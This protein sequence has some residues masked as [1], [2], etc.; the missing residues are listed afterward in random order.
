MS[1]LT[2]EV[3]HRYRLYPVKWLNVSWTPVTGLNGFAGVLGQC[4]GL[5]YLEICNNDIGADGV[6]RLSPGSDCTVTITGCPL[7][8]EQSDQRCR[9]RE[10]C[11]SG[12]TSRDT[13]TDTSH[14]TVL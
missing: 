6:E 2:G 14:V 9:D 1:V 11:R 13:V 8:L 5:T 12:D 4:T 7:F 3:A 10:F